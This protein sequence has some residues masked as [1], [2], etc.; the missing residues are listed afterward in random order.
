MS[1][2]VAGIW[3]YRTGDFIPTEF[4]G[5]SQGLA[6]ALSFVGANGGLIQVCSGTFT[7]AGLTLVSNLTLQGAGIGKTVIKLQNSGN[8]FVMVGSSLTDVTVRDLSIDGNKA[9][10]STV[11]SALRVTQCTRV[12]F[13]NLHVHDAKQDGFYISGCTDVTVLACVS[14]TNDRNGYSVGDAFGRSVRVRFVGCTSSGHTASGAIGFSLEPA[15]F[16]SVVGCVSN[17]DYR[18]ITILGGSADSATHNVVDGNSIIDFTTSGITNNPGTGGSSHN[19][20]SNNTLRPGAAAT[21]GIEL[22]GA[23]DVTVEGNRMAAFGAATAST[24]IFASTSLTRFVIS[25]N[26]VDGSGNYGIIVTGG[27]RGSIVGNVVRNASTAASGVRDG[28]RLTDCVDVVVT[29]NNIFDDQG[30]PTTNYAL[31]TSGSSDRITVVGNQFRGVSNA[32]VILMVGNN[33]QVASNHGQPIPAVASA[34]ALTLPPHH[35]GVV[36]VTG[37]TNV[38]SMTIQPAG[39]TVT[40]IFAGALTFTD[41]NNLLL[42]A[43]AN[44]VTT[45]NDVIHLISDGANW[46]EL[47]RSVN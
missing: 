9:N 47:A 22:T 11:A 27:A 4:P 23:T 45:A 20:I 30:G 38:T 17:G 31:Q 13:E 10:Q 40:L 46:L 35:A 18:G 28:L 7:V 34:A 21:V 36:S 16:S 42:N 26:H 41:G 43:N 1:S 8:T 19:V 39:R 6:D 15:S 14:D 12:R 2:G 25:G 32:G 33:N 3:V 5:S 29:G 24:G 37:T 44:F